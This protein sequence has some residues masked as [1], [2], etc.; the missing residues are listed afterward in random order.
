MDTLTD[1]SR[2]YAKPED[3]ALVVTKEDGTNV[4][5]SKVLTLFHDQLKSVIQSPSYPCVGAK[6]ALERGTYRISLYPAIGSLDATKLLH[7]DL[8]RFVKERPS[9]KA[10]YRTFIALFDGPYFPS[11]MEFEG[12]LWR[13][14]QNLHDFDSPLYQWDQSVSS[15]PDDPNF[16]FSVAGTAFFIV[17]LH[18][19]S[20][21]IA[22]KFSIPTLVFNAHDQFES[23]RTMNLFDKL[24][25]AIRNRDK[26]LQGQV[27]PNLIDFGDASEARQYS[28]VKHSGFWKCPFHKN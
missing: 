22:R 28:G 25:A 24:K 17:G 3:G 8:E 1:D 15:D 19:A 21:R 7:R 9:M 13:Q 18:P 4:H 16:S 6:S 26:G 5:A 12:A 11:E 2:N 27:N 10:P 20:S 23:L 14:L